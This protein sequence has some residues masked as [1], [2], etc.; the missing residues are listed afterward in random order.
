MIDDPDGF[1]YVT[2]DPV[3]LSA[4]T[5][6]VV[7]IWTHIDS[8]GYESK[9]AIRVW[10]TCAGSDTVL[11]VIAGVLD[12]EAHPV[13]ADG[14]QLAE[15]VWIPHVA[16][17]AGCGTAT[18]SFGCQ[19]NSNSEECWFDLIEFYD[20]A[21]GGDAAGPPLMI[22][23]VFDLTTPEGGTSGKAVQLTATA[24]ITDLSVFGVGV[25]NNEDA[26][27]WVGSWWW[28]VRGGHD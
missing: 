2:L 7:S 18:L 26:V 28:N 11:D 15:N 3:D 25:A 13:G 24:D 27:L 23:S 8:T 10:A 22:K 5:T 1:A 9:D 16:S 20:A 19:T 4:M 17:L 12:D 6:P 14:Q 21:G